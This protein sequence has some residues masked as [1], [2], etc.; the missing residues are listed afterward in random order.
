MPEYWLK[1]RVS[2]GPW[3][4]GKELALN[5]VFTGIARA[6]TEDEIDEYIEFH[7]SLFKD[8]PSN[9]FLKILKAH[10]KY[11]KSRSSR[12]FPIIACYSPRLDLHFPD[13]LEG[14]LFYYWREDKKNTTDGLSCWL[15]EYFSGLLEVL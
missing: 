4:A 9:F 10:K 7:H 5:R 1:V 12:L 8:D 6:L 3:K 14:A 11:P 15:S 13:H 2:K